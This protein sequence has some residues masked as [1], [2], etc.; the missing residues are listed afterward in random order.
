MTYHVS[1]PVN[2][3]LLL[4]GTDA[5]AT[6]RPDVYNGAPSSTVVNIG[7]N[8]T[9][10]GSGNTNVMYCFAPIDGF[11]AFGSYAGNGSST[12]GPFIY[13]GFRPA[14]VLIKRSAG[15][16]ADWVVFDDARNTSN[17]TTQ[18][19]IPNTAGAEVTGVGTVLDLVSNGFLPR[20]AGTEVNASG[21]TYVYAAF[22]EFPFK[23]SR[24]R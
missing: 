14:Y 15:G 24:A 19:L 23:Y 3:Y 22:A 9:V 20:N 21:S 2:S 5:P 11:S 10:N 13:T 16:T 6:S 12:L 8:A 4:N 7:N 17:L 1:I 18:L